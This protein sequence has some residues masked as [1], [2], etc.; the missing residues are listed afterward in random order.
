M[1][2]PNGLKY[3]AS[4]FPQPLYIVGG[5]VRDAFLGFNPY[6]YDICSQLE[7]NAVV[8]LLKNT[9]G[10][11]VS[12]TSPKLGTLKIDYLGTSYEYT[13]FRT[14]S[15]AC[16]GTHAP[17]AIAFTT[18]IVEDSLRRD[19]TINALY[20]DI[21]ADTLVDPLHATADL[22][23]RILRTTRTAETV[24]EEDALRLLRAV[25][26][27]AETGCTIAPQ[28]LTAL[29]TNAYKLQQIAVERIADELNKMLVAD[30]KNK[31]SDAHTN[32]ISLL[33]QCDLMQHIF[34]ELVAIKKQ[35]PQDFYKMMLALSQS[36][37]TI[38]LA[39]LLHLLPAD[40]VK[41]AML[42]L[43]YSTADINKTCS[44]IANHAFDC[45]AMDIIKTRQFI[46]SNF[47]VIDDIISLQFAKNANSQ[48]AHTLTATKSDMLAHSTPITIADLK[49]NGTDLISLNIPPQKRSNALKALL[50][51]TCNYNLTTKSSQL[52]F[53]KN[54]NI[55]L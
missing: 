35:T 46:Q 20:Y 54:L 25:R 15:Y 5:C 50:T 30:T 28:T 11:K 34:P 45:N 23:N 42:R 16:D 38:R 9:A 1:H 22:T 31:I 49:V 53:L 48:S 52:D 41:L 19:F 27:S 32:A 39:T 24:F 51:A 6:D 36:P 40:V 4:L 47:N 3:L 14:D 43:K 10:I 7:P 18:S 8:S 29:K 2:L 37:S 26:I 44:I 17:T 12:T 33:I 21:M 55:T 13:T